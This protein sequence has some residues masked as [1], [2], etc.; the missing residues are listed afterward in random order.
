MAFTETYR[1]DICSKPKR[2]RGRL[3]ARIHRT[4][5]AGC[6]RARAENVEDHTLEYSAVA[7]A[8]CSPFMRSPLCPDLDGPLD[9]R[10]IMPSGLFVDV[11]TPHPRGSRLSLPFTDSMVTERITW[12]TTTLGPGSNAGKSGRT[13]AHPGERRS[14]SR[15]RRNHRQSLET[16]CARQGRTSAVVREYKGI[17]R[18]P[19]ADEP[20]RQRTPHEAGAGRR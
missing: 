17:P 4:C 20:V 19:R 7:R 14:H 18:Q 11:T 9:A 16:I 5:V 1:C 2:R 13:Q 6:Q 8:E 15:D 3:V 12:H 10:G